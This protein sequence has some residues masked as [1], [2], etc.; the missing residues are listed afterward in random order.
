MIN[1]RFKTIL[2]ALCIN[3]CLLLQ[4]LNASDKISDPEHMKR[5]IARHSTYV[6]HLT[7]KQAFLQAIT[8]GNIKKTQAYL[9][10]SDFRELLCSMI[11]EYQCKKLGI[12]SDELESYTLLKIAQASLDLLVKGIEVGDCDDVRMYCEVVDTSQ[13]DYPLESYDAFKAFWAKHNPK[14]PMESF[15]LTINFPYMEFDFIDPK[16]PDGHEVWVTPP[17]SFE[18]LGVQ[19]FE[20]EY[21]GVLVQFLKDNKKREI[22]AALNNYILYNSVYQK[23]F[24]PYSSAIKDG[25]SVMN[26]KSDLEKSYEASLSPAQKQLVMVAKFMFR[27]TSDEKAKPEGYVHFKDV[28]KE[29]DLQDCPW[30]YQPYLSVSLQ[31][32]DNQLSHIGDLELFS[33]SVKPLSTTTE[34]IQKDF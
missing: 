27:I 24:A 7:M 4:P 34:K 2:T 28:F 5:L 19:E 31:T 15:Q 9:D 12:K 26:L 6:T 14:K 13:G 10:C 16:S 23:F 3:T 32:G 11:E 33:L 18:P 8:Q 22:S 25:A 29:L 21:I 1:R 17:I 30:M 20:Q